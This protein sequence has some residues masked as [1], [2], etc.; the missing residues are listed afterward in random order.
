MTRLNIKKIQSLK[1]NKKIVCLTAYSKSIAKIID[2]YVDII[3]IGDSVGTTIYG[4]KNTQGVT[5]DMMMHH[6]KTVFNSSS[7]AFTIIDMPFNSYNNNKKALIN[8]KKLLKYTNCQSVKIETDHKNINIVSHLKSN[9]IAVVSHMG[10]TP[11]QYK[12]F[13]KIR[14]VGRNKKQKKELIDLAIKLEKAGASM[15]VLECIK[16][17]IAKE[18]TNKLNI[19]TIG[20]GASPVC[21]G[22]VLVINDILNTENKDKQPKFIKSYI[23]INKIIKKAV[24]QFSQEVKNKQFPK[25]KN[26]Y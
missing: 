23:N 3:L 9:G 12:D 6:G 25:I 14:S 8:A 17:S 21:D 22:Q 5:L 19:P 18:I 11:Q 15:I 26:T 20:I 1:K 7:K 2:D 10:V 13:T 16:E 4:M 24:K